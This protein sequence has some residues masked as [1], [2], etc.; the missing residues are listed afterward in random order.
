M[1]GPGLRPS[2]LLDTMELT[3]KGACIELLDSDRQVWI[4]LYIL[5]NMK[6][7]RMIFLSTIGYIVLF[8]V[9]WALERF[10]T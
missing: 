5:Q 7:W 8:K 3:E 2:A 9:T 4:L 6:E 10:C 1:Q